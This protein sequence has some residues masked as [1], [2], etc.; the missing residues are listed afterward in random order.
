MKTRRRPTRNWEAREGGGRGRDRSPGAVV[1]ILFLGTTPPPPPKKGGS[2]GYVGGGREKLPTVPLQ[3]GA[4]VRPWPCNILGW[5]E[6]GCA[7][8]T[9][10]GSGGERWKG[11]GLGWSRN[12][13]A[14]PEEERG[15]RRGGGQLLVPGLVSLLPL[16]LSLSLRLGNF[17]R[18]RESRNGL[19]LPPLCYLGGKKSPLRPGLSAPQNDFFALLAGI[20]F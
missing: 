14:K 10:P 18:E 8:Q 17:K 3:S 7:R 9:M 4:R 16:S 13:R 1:W 19:D 11:G 6:G 2:S 5:L 20:A 15:E 12:L